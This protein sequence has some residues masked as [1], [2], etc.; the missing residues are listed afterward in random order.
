MADI[1]MCK[2]FKC[3]IREKCYRYT[4]T[5]GV[6]QYYNNHRY[7]NECK[8]FWDNERINRR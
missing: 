7:E 3:P 1:D 5:K 6:I 8:Y 2:G 4:A